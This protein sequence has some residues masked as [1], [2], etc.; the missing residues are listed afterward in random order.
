MILATPTPPIPI[1]MGA[2][3]EPPPPQRI[4]S[5][6]RLPPTATNMATRWALPHLL[7]TILATAT[8]NNKAI[9]PT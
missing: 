2:L 1:P 7:M 4:I 5:A 8:P 9:T 6:T 3:R